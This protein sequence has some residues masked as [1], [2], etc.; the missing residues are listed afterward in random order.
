MK[1]KKIKFVYDINEYEKLLKL[2]KKLKIK[3]SGKN[4]KQNKYKS[5]LKI[6]ETINNMFYVKISKRQFHKV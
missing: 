1:F 6:I 3:V 4:K 2:N 5:I